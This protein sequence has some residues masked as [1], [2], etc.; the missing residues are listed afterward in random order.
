MFRGKKLIL[1]LA[2]AAVVLVGSIG[3]VVLAAGD[4][5]CDRPGPRH[6]AIMERVCE[7]YEENTGVAINCTALKGA[8]SQAQGEMFPKDR[9]DCGRM[10]P[11]DWPNRGEIDPEAMQD[12]LQDL[13]DQGKITQEQFDRMKTRMESM[14]D[15]LSGFGFRGMGGRPHFGFP[16]APPQP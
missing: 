11:K 15:N 5:D 6:E 2:L 14:S 7:I 9:A 16:P 4:E 13:L 12:R 1:V 3:G 8:F 10:L